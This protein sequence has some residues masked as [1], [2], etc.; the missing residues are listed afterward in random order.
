MNKYFLHIGL[1][2]T[3]TK[4]FQ[5]KVFP[6]LPKDKFIYNPPKLMQLIA[7]L[8]KAKDVDL[9]IVLDAIEIEKQ[10]LEDASNKKI[11]ISREIMSGDLFSFYTDHERTHARIHKA[12][13][14]AHIICMLRYQVDWIISCYRESIH[15]HHYQTIEEFL[16]L[17]DSNDLFVKTRYVD[18][19]LPS[20]IE[21]LRRLFPAN[22]ISFFFFEDF[23]DNKEE[24]VRNISEIFG[25]KNIPILYDR[26]KVPN[27]GYSAFSICLSILRYK[28]IKLIGLY[29]FL[30][31]R[32]IYFMGPNGI[33][34]GFEHLSVLKKE[35]YWHDGFLRDNEELR[36]KNYPNNLT[37]I[38]KIKMELSWR[39]IIKKRIDKLFYWDWDMLGDLRDELNDYFWN[40][41]KKL[42]N[43]LN[44]MDIPP[45][46]T[47][48]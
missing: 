28:I 18:F 23:K 41:N 21:S 20:I 44:R 6:N 15:L 32:P 29:E 30:I 27:R 33:P 35:K 25:I 8:I 26:D 40:E 16:S 7:D 36:S 31:H 3:G 46:Y 38:E 24:M 42:A 47:K 4:F 1:H 10:A 43:A 22:Q 9:S 48:R 37:F 11:V 34:A 19:D 5:H 13:T 17:R 45:N 12:F 2:K 39:S 14:D